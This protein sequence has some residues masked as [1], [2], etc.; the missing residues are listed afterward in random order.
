MYPPFSMKAGKYLKFFSEKQAII[1]HHKK[2]P[3]G[4]QPA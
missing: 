3:H 2:A 1:F 4:I